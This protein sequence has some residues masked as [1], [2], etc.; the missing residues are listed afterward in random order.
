MPAYKTNN[1]NVRFLRRQDGLEVKE[2]DMFEL[3]LRSEAQLVPL[4]TG[5]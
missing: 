3:Y 1:N 5:S 4:H 2:E